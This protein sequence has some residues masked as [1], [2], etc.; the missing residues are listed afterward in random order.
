MRLV[1]TS[2]QAAPGT[3]RCSSP[4]I[5]SWSLATAMSAAARKSVCLTSTRTAN[6]LSFDLSPALERLLFFAQL[7]EPS[8][9]QQTDLLRSSY[10]MRTLNDPYSRA[11]PLFGNGTMMPTWKSFVAL[12]PP[13]ASIARKWSSS[14]LWPGAAHGDRLRSRERWLRLSGDKC[15]RTIRATFLCFT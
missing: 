1:R 13:L 14:R 8:D 12:F 7:R 6:S 10:S 9:R 3:T 2:I 15:H 5:T 4:A 11:F